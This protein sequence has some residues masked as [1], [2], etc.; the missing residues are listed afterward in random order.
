[1]RDFLQTF[2]GIGCQF[3][4]M[5]C[6]P[7]KSDS[8]HIVK[9]FCQS[10]RTDIIG[11]TCFKFEGKLIKSRF[12]KRDMLNH[13]SSSLI[14]RQA[15]QPFFFPIQYANTCRSIYLM[16]REDQKIG[17]QVLY[18]YF[19]MRNGL[20]S[21]HYERYS[22]RMGGSNHFLYR[23]YCAQH[24]RYLNN[25]DN[26]CTF[27]EK[28]LVFIQ[29]QFPFIIHR[30]HFDCNSFAG[31]QQLPGNDVAVMF[32]YRNNHFITFLHKLIS[33]A[34]NKQINAFR[35]PPRKDNLIRSGGIDKPAYRLTGGLMQFCCLL[36]EI[37]YPAMH[38]GI[39]G[40]IFIY[41]RINHQTGLLSRCTVI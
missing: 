40:I 23:I 9:S 13:F 6:N 31:G 8:I 5:S 41:N 20:R 26:L 21:I 34:G 3:M 29:Q 18:I 36:G 17:I 15:I 35:R 24:I 7:V 12:L 39:D 11:R 28:L 37:M 14:R 33:K 2:Q 30:N 32:H 10:S 27:G 4:F 25:A 19:H 38:I 16:S 22:M 1:M